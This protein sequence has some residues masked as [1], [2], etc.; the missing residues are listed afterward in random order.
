MIVVGILYSKTYPKEIDGMVLDQKNQWK[1][2][3]YGLKHNFYLFSTT[4]VYL[5]IVPY[6]QLFS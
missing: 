2:M 4:R 1:M 6:F 3:K 5:N